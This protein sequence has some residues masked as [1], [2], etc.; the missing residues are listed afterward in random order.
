MGKSE[1]AVM[2]KL[3]RLGL[4]VVQQR[5]SNWTTSSTLVA[6]E[7]IVS[8]ELYFV[9]KNS[10]PQQFSQFHSPNLEYREGNPCIHVSS[11]HDYFL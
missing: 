2:K 4:K 9:A 8:E 11:N 7:I 6:S 10:C 5:E 1:E 3:Q